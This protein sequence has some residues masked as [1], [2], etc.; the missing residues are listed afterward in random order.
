MIKILLNPSQIV[1]VDT[2]GI[3]FKRGDSLRKIDTLYDHSIVI[4]NGIIKD[5][6]SNSEAEKLKSQAGELI[7]LENKIVLPGLVEC[8]THSA[9][10]GSRANEFKERLNGKSY[11]DIAKNG[12]GINSTVQSVRKS[13][14]E[15]IY[16]N[17]FRTINN[18]ISQGITT[19]EIK[20]GYGLDFENE[21]KLL[22]VINSLNN[23][24]LIDIV[25]TFLGAH[26]YPPDV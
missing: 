8:H 18:F 23:N 15:D 26:T 7:D 22:N 20:S 24:C 12:G 6:I 5:I 4:E 2:K 3:N 21:I 10:M 16:K 17:T 9:F 25:P 14:A 11:E 1:T 13:S 19:L